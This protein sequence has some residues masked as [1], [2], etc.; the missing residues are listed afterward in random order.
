MKIYAKK[1]ASPS[2]GRIPKRK[3]G[4]IFYVNFSIHSQMRMR[5]RR[6]GIMTNVTRICV[7]FLILKR[8]WRTYVR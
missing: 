2:S 3:C 1:C 6:T 4:P 8:D 7:H 5:T